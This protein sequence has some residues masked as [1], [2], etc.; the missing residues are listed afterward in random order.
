[1]NIYEVTLSEPHGDPGNVWSTATGVARTAMSAGE[2]ALRTELEP[3]GES[4]L[5]Q[6]EVSGIRMLASCEF[7]E[8]SDS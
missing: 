3:L 5:L 8:N 4:E 7:I 6:L 2:I 1:M